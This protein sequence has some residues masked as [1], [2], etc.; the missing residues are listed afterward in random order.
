MEQRLTPEQAWENFFAWIKEQPRWGELS[1]A[2]K[3]EL[4]KADRAHR[5]GKPYRLGV[6]WTKTLLGKYAPG[7]Y[8]FKDV[9]IVHE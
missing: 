4:Y 1:R 5:T 8:E 9:V 3:N 7:R 2:E 6:V